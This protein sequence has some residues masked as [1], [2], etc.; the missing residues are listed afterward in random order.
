MS[1][2]RGAGTIN[3]VSCGVGSNLCRFSR[4]RG[5]GVTRC[6]A[7]TGEQDGPVGSGVSGVPDKASS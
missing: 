7:A 5:V 6:S 3:K 4:F 1:G 2:S